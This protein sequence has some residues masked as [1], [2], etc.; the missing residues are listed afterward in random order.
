[1]LPSIRR[2]S[3]TNASWSKLR[4]NKKNDKISQLSSRSMKNKVE[5]YH[6]KF[7]SSANKKNHVSDCNTNVKN[8]QSVLCPS[9]SSHDTSTIVVPPGHILTTTIVKKLFLAIKGYG[10]LKMGNILILRI[11]YIEGLGHNLF[12]VVQFFDS[13]LKLAKQGL[14]KGLPTLKYTKD[15]LCSAC[16][17]GK[18][19]K[20]SLPHKPEP[21]TN[22]K[23]QMLHMD[24]C[25]PIRVESINGP[26]LYGFTSGHISSELVLNK[27]A[28]TSAK[29]PTKKEYDLLFQP[30][31]DEYF[32][33][34]SV[35]STPISVTTLLPSDT[36][37]ESSS[38][39]INQEAPSP[40][41]SPNNETLSLPINSTNVETD[42]EVAEFDSDAFTNPFAPP[43]TSLA[44]SSSRIPKNY[45]EAI[46][47]DQRKA[48][49]KN[50]VGSKPCKRKSKNLSG[51][52]VL[53]NK[54]RLVA[55]GY[56]QEEGI[57]F[58]ESFTLIL[59]EEV[60]G[61]QLEGFVN[62]DNLNH[63]FRLKKAL[64]GL[65]QAPRAWHDLLSKF[66]L[67]QKFVKGVVDPTLFTRKEGNDLILYGL[68]QCDAVDIPM[69]GQSKLDEDPNVT[70]VDP[71]RNIGM[72]TEK[73]LTAVK[74]VF[75]YLKGTINI[76]LWYSKDTGFNLTT[77]VDADHAGCQ[78]SRRSTSGSAQFLGEKLLTDY[79]FNFNKIPLYSDSKSA[80]ALSCN[81][82]Q[83]Y[84]TKHIAVRY[85]FIKEQVENEVVELYFVK[86]D[87]QLADIFTKAF[88][89]ERFEFLINRLSMQSITP[90]EL[91]RLTESD[92]E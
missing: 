2:V 91:K 78:D 64:Y 84:K 29:P 13:D 17:M 31:F 21:S 22:E 79:G 74:Q 63:V 46:D 61:S 85:H 71:T 92:E 42:E 7:K 16:Q 87:Y 57:D 36:A 70:P 18:S 33:S 76:G 69:V 90:E 12:S 60:Y 58:E 25:G 26:K 81:T 77:F 8:N 73:H 24:L 27:A 48:W 82:M 66:L 59:K 39:T 50:Q 4:S 43:E 86:T 65:K 62:Q 67:R 53:K 68:D 1:M 37:R 49:E 23:L 20:E 35:V 54:A 47:V 5:A 28:S 88:V 19:K 15:H 10:D 51:L 44:E 83:H 3:S 55:K 34:L 41:T 6:R 40:S 45:K 52:N 89:R 38:A 30:M 32:K 14:V 80:I 75:G 56:R 9:S 11:Y 72:R